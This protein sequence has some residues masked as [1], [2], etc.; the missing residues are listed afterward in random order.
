[1]THL[2]MKTLYLLAYQW[3]VEHE[4]DTSQPELEK[5]AQV[6]TNYLDFVWKQK[7]RKTSKK[8]YTK[9]PGGAGPGKMAPAPITKI[10]R[11]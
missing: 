6:I 8:T 1:M 4:K 11:T 10:I 2:S 9:G 3:I 7:P 5:Q